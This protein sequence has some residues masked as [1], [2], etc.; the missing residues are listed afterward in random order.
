MKRCLIFALLLL[1]LIPVS[2]QQEEAGNV[3][4]RDEFITVYDEAKPDVAL[5]EIRIPFKGVEG[6][7]LHVLTNVELKMTCSEQGWFVIKDVREV[8]GG[9]KVITYDAASMIDE[10]SLHSRTGNLSFSCPELYFGKF[11]K[12][13]QGFDQVWEETFSDTDTGCLKLGG[14]FQWTTPELSQIASHY[15]DYVSFNAWAEAAGDITGRNITMDVSISG[16]AVFSEIN[17]TTYRINVPLGNGPEGSN[18]RWLMISSGGKVMNAQTTLTFSVHNP[19]GVTVSMSNLRVY[20]VT[21]SDYEDFWEDEE[22]FND[23]QG[24]EED[25][26]I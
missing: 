2:C 26:W 19:S 18:L 4:L 1:P 8:D 23:D 3:P 5:D 13:S 21:E 22:E 12:V 7:K 11:M 6:G 15:Y 9:H 10:N 17:R 14:S 16:G 20:K 25:D 24:G